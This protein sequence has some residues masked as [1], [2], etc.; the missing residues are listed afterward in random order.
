MRK[1]PRFYMG[2][3]ANEYIFEFWA[4]GFSVG[5]TFRELKARGYK[6]HYRYIRN[7]YVLHARDYAEYCARSISRFESQLLGSGAPSTEQVA[8]TVDMLDDLVNECRV[9]WEPEP[10]ELTTA[11]K[12]YCATDA[13]VFS[14]PVFG[15]DAKKSPIVNLCLDFPN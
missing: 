10:F 15:I 2:L 4:C 12:N 8:L 13:A 7:R 6:I 1:R 9:A 3:S 11:L 5:E 14:H